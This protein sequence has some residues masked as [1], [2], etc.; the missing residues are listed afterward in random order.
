MCELVIAGGD[1]SKI[2]EAIEHPF[3]EIALPVD[4]QIDRPLMLRVGWVEMTVAMSRNAR[5]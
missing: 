3:D 2:L 1:L 5:S 4:I